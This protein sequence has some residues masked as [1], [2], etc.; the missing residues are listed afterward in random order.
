VEDTGTVEPFDPA[1]AVWLGL[2]AGEVGAEGSIWHWLL[3]DATAVA[4]DPAR[5]AAV[6]PV[7]TMATPASTAKTEDSALFP[8]VRAPGREPSRGVGSRFSIIG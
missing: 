4:C 7:H 8:R 2:G 6:A 3:V 5:T 1:V